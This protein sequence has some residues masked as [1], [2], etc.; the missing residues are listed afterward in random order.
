MTITKPIYQML[1]LLM[2]VL[3][4]VGVASNCALADEFENFDA[5]APT[6]A[7]IPSLVGQSN[8]FALE[9]PAEAGAQ[10]IALPY[11]EHASR[12]IAPFPIQLNQYVRR[13]LSDFTN[14][15]DRL[16]DTFD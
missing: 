9:S 4:A 12:P 13:Y 8:G 11:V 7:A 2:A 1:T 6:E 16:Q 10:P 15:P 3:F 14:S 5:A